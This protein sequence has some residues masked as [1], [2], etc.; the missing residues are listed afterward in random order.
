MNTSDLL[1]E[2]FFYD[3]SAY[4]YKPHSLRAHESL[5]THLNP[6]LHFINT[7]SQLLFP[8]YTPVIWLRLLICGDS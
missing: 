3:T 5:G 7:G 8:F 6:P 4:G 1:N 2:L